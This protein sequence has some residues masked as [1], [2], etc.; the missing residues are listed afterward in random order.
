M[1][2]NFENLASKYIDNK[3]EFFGKLQKAA[4]DIG[5]FECVSINKKFESSL[6]DEKFEINNV[7]YF[8][9]IKNDDDFSATICSEIKKLKANKEV[10][11]KLPKVNK[12]HEG[13]K[14]LY[15]G[16]SSGVFS[17]RLNQ[18]FGNG[19]NQTYALH[20]DLWK[21]IALLKDLEIELYYLSI[22]LESYHFKNKSEESEC[23]EYLETIL[24]L[25]LKPILGRTGH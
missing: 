15:V 18:H 24:H 8:F 25:N 7:L 6:K 5:A 23:L 19:S 4:S 9:K 12:A 16:K 1:I 17:N 10:L 20:F 14:I 22:D 21:D 3:Q 13:D 2:I 11:K